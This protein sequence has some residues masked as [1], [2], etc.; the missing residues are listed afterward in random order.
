MHLATENTWR[1]SYVGAEIDGVDMWDAIV[2]K[3]SS[4]HSEIIHYVSVDNEAGCVQRDMYKLNYQ[5]PLVDVGTP[6]CIFER[7][8]HP[9]SANFVCDDVVL[10]S[11]TDGIS[12]MPFSLSPQLTKAILC[13]L[14]LMNIFV[15]V[16]VCCQLRRS[17]LTRKPSKYELVSV[18]D[19]THSKVF[20][21]TA[22]SEHSGAEGA[23]VA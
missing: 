13:V 21:L 4:P 20:E 8:G 3:M 19:S 15:M 5:E 11:G 9:Q 22:T 16:V 17:R 2:L 7:D 6:E 1:G 10:L 14:A 18:G 12:G 23:V